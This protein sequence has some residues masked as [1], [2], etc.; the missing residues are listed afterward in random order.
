MLGAEERD[1]S[2]LV[3]VKL[4]HQTVPLLAKAVQTDDQELPPKEFKY[5]SK[6][7]R[8]SG[9][10]VTTT[11][12]N[13]PSSRLDVKSSRKLDAFTL[14]SGDRLS[15]QV[16]QDGRRT[17]FSA[18]FSPKPQRKS[19]EAKS[20]LIKNRVYLDRDID[21][22]SLPVTKFPPLSPTRVNLVT[23]K[24]NTTDADMFREYPA[25]HSNMVS[26]A[27]CSLEMDIMI[28][29]LSL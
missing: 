22:G 16:E 27:V 15:T 7:R 21:L 23:M 14:P 5:L 4:T 28:P 18:G 6:S 8:K 12:A 26:Q 1:S 11:N 29:D 19:T 20:Q 24:A 9:T 17:S 25:S 3:I 2:S 10:Y 13:M